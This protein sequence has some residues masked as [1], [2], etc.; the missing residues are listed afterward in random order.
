MPPSRR[1]IPDSIRLARFLVLGSL[2]FWIAACGPSGTRT[3]E[4]A[5][6]D[7]RC[8]KGMY[9]YLLESIPRCVRDRDAGV[10]TR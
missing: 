2:V 3:E 7:G 4:Y 5:P 8:P 10:G 9:P 6:W 1:L